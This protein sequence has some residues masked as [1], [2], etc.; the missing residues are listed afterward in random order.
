MNKKEFGQSGENKA[1]EYLKSRGYQILDRNFR[2]RFGELDL[3]AL[4]DTTLVFVEVKTRSSNNFGRPEEAVTAKKL[5]HIKLTGEYYAS[6][7]PNLPTSHRIDVVSIESDKIQL[8]N[9][10]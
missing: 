8:I 10:S 3:I 7:H 5:A 9:V 4:D 6:L 2:S 1:E